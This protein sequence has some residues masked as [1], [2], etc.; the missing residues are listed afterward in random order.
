MSSQKDRIF[1]VK[2]PRVP[3]RHSSAP[4]QNSSLAQE[5]TG[6]AQQHHSMS[7]QLPGM[8]QEDARSPRQHHSMA[9]QL[10]SLTQ[11]Y[12][13][14]AHQQYGMAQQHP[15][16]AQQL[17]S[18]AQEY[19]GMGQQHPMSGLQVYPQGFFRDPSGSPLHYV[20]YY[21]DG[22]Y[23]SDGPVNIGVAAAVRNNTVGESFEVRGVLQHPEAHPTEM[24]AKLAA[25]VLALENAVK[26]RDELAPRTA[27]LRLYIHTDSMDA[28]HL[29]KHW[30][31]LWIRPDSKD[32]WGRELGNRD[33]W[34]GQRPRTRSCVS[35]GQWSIC[36]LI[37]GRMR[38]LLRC[39]MR[40]LIWRRE[41]GTLKRRCS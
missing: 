38:G 7:Q 20:H 27:L 21:T 25:I 1:G 17:P 36:A 16:M 8:A 31:E 5:D 35:Q 24:R 29:I 6:M 22:Q 39:A 32:S 30:L 12:T 33:L 37:E 13:S 4:R 19:T 15:S 18:M 14:M 3:Q 2:I 40:S 11:E 34:S 23:R 9:Q 28:A 26:R 10:P 41:A